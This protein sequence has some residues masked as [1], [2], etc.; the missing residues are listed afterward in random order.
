MIESIEL[1]HVQIGSKSQWFYFHDERVHRFQGKFFVL[2]NVTKERIRAL[3]N[4][5]VQSEALKKIWLTLAAETRDL[6]FATKLVSHQ[7][8]KANSFAFGT[9]VDLSY[10]VCHYNSDN[11]TVGSNLKVVKEEITC[12]FQHDKSKLLIIFRTTNGGAKMNGKRESFETHRYQIL[13]KYSSLNNILLA[14]SFKNK[15]LTVY[16]MLSHPPLLYE[17]EQDVAHEENGRRNDADGTRKI[18]VND[19][20]ASDNWVRVTHFH[21]I[22]A[23]DFGKFN[24]IRLEFPQIRN[25]DY[26]KTNLDK[27]VCCP[28]SVISCIQRFKNIPLHFASITYTQND[29]YLKPFKI[30]ANLPFNVIYALSSVLSLNSQVVDELRFK[31]QENEFEA[32]VLDFSNRNAK[33]LEEA[34][35]EIFYSIER[36]LFIRIVPALQ[37]VFERLSSDTRYFEKSDATKKSAQRIRRAILTP[38]RLIINPPQP[39]LESRFIRNSDPDFALRLL[40]RDDDQQSLAFTVCNFGSVKRQRNFLDKTVIEP[41]ARGITIGNRKYEFLGSS[42]SQLRDIGM[43]LYAEDNLSR[44]AV[45]IRNSIGQISEIRNVAKYVAR[46]GLAF[47]QALAHIDVPQN[48]NIVKLLPD[49]KG[50]KHPHSG[51]PYTFS[52]GVGMISPDLAKKVCVALGRYNIPSAFQIRYAGCKGMLTL[53][54]NLKGEQMIIRESMQ[55]FKSSSTSLEIIKVSEPR[56]VYLNRPLITLLDQL[57]VPAKVFLQMQMKILRTLTHSFLSEREAAKLIKSHSPL[58]LRVSFDH[59]IS[60]GI[61]LLNE[62]FFRSVLDTLMARC[63]YDLKMKARIKVPPDSGRIM[64]GV[65]DDTRLLQYGEVFV[66]YSDEEDTS[67]RKILTGEVLVTKY[68]C[69]HPGDVRK[70]KAVDIPNLHHICD[71]IV[72]P[73]HGARP[74]PDEMAGSDLDGDEYSVIWYKPLLFPGPNHA[75]MDYPDTTPEQLNRE[76][77]TEDILD[78]YATFIQYNSVG[79]IASAHLAFADRLEKGVFDKL[80][81]KLAEKYAVSLDFAKTGKNEQLSFKDRP[82]F[83]PDFMD[84][85]SEKPTYLSRRALGQLYRQVCFFELCLNEQIALDIASDPNPLLVHP[86]WKQFRENAI[87]AYKDYVYAI[88]SYQKQFNVDSEAALLSGTSIKLSKYASSKNEAKDAHEMIDRLVKNLFKMMREVFEREFQTLYNNEEAKELRMAKASAWYVMTYELN[89]NNSSPYFGLPWIVADLLALLAKEQ[90][91]AIDNSG[92]CIKDSLEASARLIDFELGKKKNSVSEASVDSVTERIETAKRILINWLENQRELRIGL[93]KNRSQLESKLFGVLNESVLEYIHDSSQIQSVGVIVINVFKELIESMFKA[94]A[95]NN[96]PCLNALG[97]CALITLNRFIRT[98]QLYHILPTQV[99]SRV[100]QPN[101]VAMLTFHL[102]LSY[103]EKFAEKVVQDKQ[104]FV[105]LLKEAS[106]VDEITCEA[107]QQ[108]NSYW[109]LLLTASGTKWSLEIL[110]NIV[111]QPSFYKDVVHGTLSQ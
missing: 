69:M 28:W 65:L 4:N 81:Y 1:K 8:I 47:S 32:I 55:K 27:S 79:I 2:Y 9:L 52:D 111:S 63:V 71:C 16:L 84:K 41:I 106:G 89:Y 88:Q 54:P 26:L 110:R 7:K 108:S 77:R 93:K 86:N 82:T 94:D 36:G 56:A 92:E 104:A 33:V 20:T 73:S 10:F 22:K 42:T 58:Q 61:N 23:A 35:F 14:P 29:R 72:F 87:I 100:S 24:V 11:A 99:N 70:L 95:C 49:I 97:L 60:S 53:N 13:V 102:S 98:R 59:L 12:F 64:F 21:G 40:I 76:V 31:R 6:L 19:I 109:Y 51:K 25:D 3:M 46:V 37:Q 18:H 101:E 44:D 57:Q 85:F 74:H 38:T 91:S 67:D 90:R 80:C 96:D 15:T 68:P 78:F 34:F 39:F 43:F 45:A 75:P 66:Q 105:D 17:L 107:Y 48:K 103:S 5:F 50:G 83:Y 30:P 62:P